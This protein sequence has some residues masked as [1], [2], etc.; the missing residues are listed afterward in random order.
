MSQSRPTSPRQ[1]QQVFSRSWWQSNP[2][3]YDW[4]RTIQAPEGSPEFFQE[5]DQ[6]FVSSSPFYEGEPP[7][8]AL[9]PFADLAGRRVL[10]VGCG[11]GYHAQL[12]AASGCHLTAVDLTER[13]VS[14]T[15]RRLEL[16]GLSADLR[17]MDAETLEF[18]DGSFDFIWSWGVV[19]HSANTEQILREIRRI[20][21]PGGSFRCMVYHRR[22]IAALSA[23][24]RGVPMLVRGRSV[25]DVL[26]AYT[27]GWIAR[28]Y[29]QG[30][31]GALLSQ[32]GFTG[33]ETRVL[34]Q[35][36]E[37]VPLPGGAP[38]DLKG[39]IQARIPRPLTL[40]ILARFGSFLFASAMKPSVESNQRAGENA[41]A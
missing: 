35:T 26:S 28:Y 3:S 7:F 39:R 25:D 4:R 40:A 34:G 10:E 6:R 18:P 8:S 41:R 31:F 24:L 1:S 38:M 30:A 33:I 2:M 9:I 20:L 32:C 17:E 11:F 29:T 14:L 27:D 15:A 16:Q 22:S 23:V 21:R 19:H 13:A 5:I 12:L 36:S 37:L